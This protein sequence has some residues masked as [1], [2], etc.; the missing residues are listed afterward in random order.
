M[1]LTIGASAPQRDGWTLSSLGSA[2]GGALSVISRSTTDPIDVVTLALG[3]AR[4]DPNCDMLLTARVN[5]S[6]MTGNL[7]L[8]R[9]ERDGER[10]VDIRFS[11][12]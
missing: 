2:I 5:G 11:R 6:Q 12:R 7:R 1:T 9:C 4:L 10:L 8:G 3:T